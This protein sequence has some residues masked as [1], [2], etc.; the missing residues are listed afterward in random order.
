MHWEWRGLHHCASG[1]AVIFGAWCVAILPTG[2]CNMLVVGQITLLCN[3]QCLLVA[4]QGQR[5]N[6]TVLAS[7]NAS[8]N[9]VYALNKCTILLDYAHS[10]PLLA[11]AHLRSLMTVLTQ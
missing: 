3:I 5:T 9:H 8:P 11:V 6:L 7:G 1:D 4:I 2:F 10:L